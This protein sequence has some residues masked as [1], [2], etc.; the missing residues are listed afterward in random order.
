MKNIDP[1]TKIESLEKEAEYYKMQYKRTQNYLQKVLRNIPIGN[2]FCISNKNIIIQI[3]E[4]ESAT[5]ID[6][7]GVEQKF[8][9]DKSQICNVIFFKTQR[10][11]EYFE[12]KQEKK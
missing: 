2:T 6:S 7:F 9:S 4:I 10:P 12:S 8:N 11:K 3:D 1:K 5:F